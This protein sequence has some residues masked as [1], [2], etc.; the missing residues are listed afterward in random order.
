MKPPITK[1]EIINRIKLPG[2]RKTAEWLF[3]EYRD[4]I[5]RY[6]QPELRSAKVRKIIGQ[7]P[8]ALLRYGIMIIGGALLV[9]VGIAAFI[10]Y[11]PTIDIE[12]AVTQTDDGTLHYSTRIPQNAIKNSDKFVGVT[13]NSSSELPFPVE[14]EIETISETV[15]V[16]RQSAWQQATLA[17]IDKIS[18]NILLDKPI[19]VPGKILLEKQ[20]IMMWV[21]EKARK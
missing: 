3:S 21:I 19:T 12:I 18:A 17:P 9:L 7:V 4:K 14:Y 1:A 8:P 11:Q 20:S 13:L 16:S 6:R 10:P 5:D 2:K 15:K